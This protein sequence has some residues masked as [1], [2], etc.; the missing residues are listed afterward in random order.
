MEEEAFAMMPDSKSASPASVSVDEAER[1]SCTYN[2]PPIVELAV[3]MKPVR[4]DSPSTVRVDVAVNA[5]PTVSAS[6]MNALPCTEKSTPG[7]VVPMPTLPDE[8]AKYESPSIA[9]VEEPVMMFEMWKGP[10]IVEEAC[11]M[12]PFSNN[13][14]PPKVSVEEALRLFAM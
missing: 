1:W 2:V 10:E 4:V 3:E 7:D 5:P 8:I 9:I 11:E 13:P 6:F 12:N 14:S